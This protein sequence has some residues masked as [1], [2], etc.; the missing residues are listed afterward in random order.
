MKLAHVKIVGVR[1]LLFHGF[2]VEVVTN[3]NKVKDG[4]AGNSPNEW[5]KTLYEKN[6]Q[7]YLPGSY[8][9]A[10]LKNGAKYTK[11][12]RGSIQTSF[13]SCMIMKT[14]YALLNR[15]LP[16]GWQEMT[17]EEFEKDSSKPVYLDIRGVI[18]PASKGRNV[19]YRIA[20]SMGWKC[21]FEFLF[22]DTIVSTPQV[23]KIVTDAGKMSGLGDARTLGYGRF[24]IED[25][26]IKE[27]ED[28]E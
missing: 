21:E 26:T 23:K 15:H 11:A 16:E 4:S 22:D 5:K 20:C 17:S 9:S 8:F 3:L 2:N 12:G 1:P 27:D 28:Y 6:N 7:L 13:I 18:N 14:D 25:I 10:T 24:K 19:R